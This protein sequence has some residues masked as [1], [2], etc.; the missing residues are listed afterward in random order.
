MHLGTV[1]TTAQLSI[2]VIANQTWRILDAEIWQIVVNALKQRLA[3]SGVQCHIAVS[4]ERDARYAFNSRALGTHRVIKRWSLHHMCT[5]VLHVSIRN[6]CDTCSTWHC[7]DKFNLDI[8]VSIHVI[9]L[10]HRARGVVLTVVRLVAH[11][12]CHCID[13][14][15]TIDRLSHFNT[16][17][18][19]CKS[20]NHWSVRLTHDHDQWHWG[21]SLWIIDLIDS[22]M[23]M[24]SDTEV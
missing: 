22:L 9:I 19:H 23:I 2:I 10:W 18:W 16:M 5:H 24:I 3:R 7:I 14:L 21:V 11:I 4:L 17:P 6:G 20:M 15:D 12:E 1:H 8:I 13:T